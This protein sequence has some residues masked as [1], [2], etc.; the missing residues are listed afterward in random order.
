MYLPRV[1]ILSVI[2]ATMIAILT[3]CSS[4]PANPAPPEAVSNDVPG[5]AVPSAPAEKKQGPQRIYSATLN[6]PGV[7]I[8]EG[9]LHRCD[10]GLT[11]VEL[12][13][14]HEGVDINGTT[15]LISI[16]RGSFED[17]TVSASTRD[18]TMTVTFEGE[19]P[20]VVG[21]FAREVSSWKDNQ[22][23]LHPSISTQAL[24]WRADMQKNGFSLVFGDVAIDPTEVVL[25][26]RVE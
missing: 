17:P 1:G 19:I 3:S 12:P 25:C 15:A 13:T 23:E 9:N 24:G 26:L 16:D 7:S 5:V 20:F 21:A 10:E 22:G 6:A 4:D 11:D 18:D 2:A 8:G 14:Y